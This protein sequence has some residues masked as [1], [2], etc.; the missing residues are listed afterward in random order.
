[1]SGNNYLSVLLL[2][3]SQH[4]HFR[5]QRVLLNECIKNQ[6]SATGHSL[7]KIQ[8]AALWRLEAGT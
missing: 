3:N 7:A 8:M 2:H 5:S 6:Y 1:M 4:T